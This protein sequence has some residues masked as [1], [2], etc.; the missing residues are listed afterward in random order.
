MGSLARLGVSEREDLYAQFPA[1]RR[2]QHRITSE[3]SDGY[4][5]VGWVARAFD[6]WYEPGINWPP[7][8]PEPENEDDLGCYIALFES[9]GYEICEGPEHEP[10]YLKIAVY[11]DGQ[12]FQHVAKQLRGTGGWSSKAGFLHDLRHQDLEALHPSGI[13][14]NAR[15]VVYMRRPDSGESMSLEETGLIL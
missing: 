8:V 12:S 5:C 14:R 13:M 1:L 7:G 15:P 3:P 9:W 2:S 4:N 11:A 10:G 6:K